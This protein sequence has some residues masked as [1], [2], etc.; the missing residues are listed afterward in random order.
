M[1]P[2][3]IKKDKR[4]RLTNLNLSAENGQKPKNEKGA[5]K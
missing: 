1:V 2:I 3:T 4:H 5:H